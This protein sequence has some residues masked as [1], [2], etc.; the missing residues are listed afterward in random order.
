MYFF[1]F[2]VINGTNMLDF[3]LNESTGPKAGEFRQTH[4]EGP[5]IWESP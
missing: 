3:S 2:V 1:T 4:T 5:E